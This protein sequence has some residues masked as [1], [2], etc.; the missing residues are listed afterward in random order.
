MTTPGSPW[1]TMYFVPPRKRPVGARLPGSSKSFMMP[2]ISSGLYCNKAPDAE[3]K[4]NLEGSIGVSIQNFQVK[5]SSNGI[6]RHATLDLCC[7]FS[8][9]LLQQDSYYRHHKII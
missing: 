5:N 3:N 2:V 6:Q 7:K 9:S 8:H 1:I 4:K